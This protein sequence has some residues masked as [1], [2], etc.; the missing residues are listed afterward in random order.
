MIEVEGDIFG[1]DCEVIAHAVNCKGKMGSGLAKQVK[2]KY[3]NAYEEYR[4]ACSLAKPYELINSC[5]IFRA[6]PGL[7]IAN[8]FTQLHYGS[9]GKR[10]TNYEAVYSSLES[11]ERQMSMD[12][13]K[14]VAFPSG[15]CCGLG[16]GD[17]GIVEAMIGKV[18]KDSGIAHK[19]YIL[20]SRF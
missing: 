10:Y 12:R 6:K 2:D 15:M 17:W 19:I 11:L 16:G 1:A 9:D 4:N 7:W 14:S 5:L 13:L 8:L 20:S 18:F 3:P